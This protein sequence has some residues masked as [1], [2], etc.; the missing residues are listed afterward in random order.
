MRRTV[1]S[2]LL[3]PMKKTTSK[4]NVRQMEVFIKVH[5]CLIWEFA[6]SVSISR[7]SLRSKRFPWGFRANFDVLAARKLGREQKK[8]QR[9]GGEE[10]RAYLSRSRGRFRDHPQKLCNITGIST[11]LSRKNLWACRLLTGVSLRK[12]DK[13]N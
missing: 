12:A 5:L 4:K 6:L 7:G 2:S 10:K 13:F 3:K 11:Y 9:G 1:L 8:K